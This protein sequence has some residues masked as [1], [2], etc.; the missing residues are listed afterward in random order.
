ME[1][2]IYTHT[3]KTPI[4]NLFSAFVNEKLVILNYFDEEKI[5]IQLKKVKKHFKTDVIIEENHT[6]FEVLKKEL[7]EYFNKKREKFSIKYENIGT[8]FQK[9]VWSEL[10]KIPYGQ[11]ISYKQEANFLNKPTAFRAVANANA[12]NMIMILVPCHRVISA[13]GKLSGYAGGGVSNK[14]FLLNLEKS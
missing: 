10:N 7:D 8:A 6:E 4:G 13:T 14:E 1:N 9:D 3:F 5:E 2:I 12:K 11:T